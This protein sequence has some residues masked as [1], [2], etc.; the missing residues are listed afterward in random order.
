VHSFNGRHAVLDQTMVEETFV[1][2]GADKS[3]VIQVA[4]LA[5]LPKEILERLESSSRR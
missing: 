2:N 1:P 5:G 3:Y 4:R